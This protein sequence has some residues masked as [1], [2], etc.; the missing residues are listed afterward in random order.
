MMTLT[1]WDSDTLYKANEVV[2]GPDNN[3]YRSII[4]NINQTPASNPSAW[5]YLSTGGVATTTIN[6]TTVLR[7]DLDGGEAK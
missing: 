2:V 1:E 4:R 6:T 3:L 5:Q 7:T